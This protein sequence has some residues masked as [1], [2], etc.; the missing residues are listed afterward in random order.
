MT[1][2]L[3]CHWHICQNAPVKGTQYCKTCAGPAA[4][5]DFRDPKNV[6]RRRA[7]ERA[8]AEKGKS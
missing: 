2:Y 5:S 1:S 8:A 6:E 7:A 4:A 3:V